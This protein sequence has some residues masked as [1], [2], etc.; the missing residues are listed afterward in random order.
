MT[1]QA[2]M[3]QDVGGWRYLTPYAVE[4]VGK[5]FRDEVAYSD[6]MGFKL[7]PETSEMVNDKF[8]HYDDYFRGLLDGKDDDV[9]SERTRDFYNYYGTKCHVQS[10][11]YANHDIITSRDLRTTIKPDGCSNTLY[12]ASELQ[13]IKL[14]HLYLKKDNRKE[15][16][17]WNTVIYGKYYA[18]TASGE[19]IAEHDYHSKWFTP[20]VL[21]S[22][23]QNST[24][25]RDLQ[26]LRLLFRGTNF[27]LDR[28]SKIIANDATLL[29]I[30]SNVN[31]KDV[32]KTVVSAC[33]EQ[34][35][36]NVLNARLNDFGLPPLTIYENGYQLDSGFYTYIPDGLLIV[37]A[38]NLDGVP[39]GK[40]VNTLHGQSCTSSGQA[41]GDWVKIDDNCSRSAGVERRIVIEVGTSFLIQYNFPMAV[42]V[43]NTG[44]NITS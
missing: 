4:R 11:E 27:V 24:P 6:R 38:R 17:I 14:R 22:D 30:I 21:W 8:V 33:C 9:A 13:A 34:L 44:C 19:L 25:I 1:N 2:Q 15:L 28:K 43:V 7:F 3:C 23:Y 39:L 40:L 31:P 32:G 35:T 20:S 5:L 16:S 29:C 10:D 12:D 42:I 18:Q 36:E 37:I 41:T 26:K